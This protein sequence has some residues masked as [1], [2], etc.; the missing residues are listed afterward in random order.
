MD[1]QDINK[2]LDRIDVRLCLI[3]SALSR[4]DV[5]H[6]VDHEGPT[7]V[8]N[9]DDPPLTVEQIRVHL[10]GLISR[11]TVYRAWK[12]KELRSTTLGRRTISRRSWVDQWIDHGSSK[13]N[14]TKNS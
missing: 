2:R 5:D 12:R 14:Q 6:D 10:H 11:S 1:E 13:M 9:L 7:D 3:L 4:L 8:T